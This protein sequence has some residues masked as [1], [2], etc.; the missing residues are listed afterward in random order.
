MEDKL[1]SGHSV[2]P[3]TEENEKVQILSTFHGEWLVILF[4]KETKLHLNFG[5]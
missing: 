2:V 1:F 3:R 5:K 4:E